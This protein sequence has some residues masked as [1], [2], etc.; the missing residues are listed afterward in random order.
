MSLRFIKNSKLS[1]QL[2]SGRKTSKLNQPI[3]W[4]YREYRVV[5]N[6]FSRTSV[7]TEN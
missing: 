7:E 2:L 6:G 5:E 1:D 3:L 4:T